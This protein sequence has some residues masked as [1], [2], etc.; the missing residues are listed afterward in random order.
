MITNINRSVN[1][2]FSSRIIN[3][4]CVKITIF[5]NPKNRIRLF[6]RAIQLPA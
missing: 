2:I 5:Y 6:L 3:C 1:S 4:F